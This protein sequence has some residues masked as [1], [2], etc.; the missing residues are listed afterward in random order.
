MAVEHAEAPG[1]HREQA[2]AGEQDA[3]DPDRESALLAVKPWRDQR[4]EERRRDD[5]DEHE[6]RDDERQQRRDGARD[7][8]GLAAIAAREQ[9]GIDRNERR[10]ERALAEEILQDIG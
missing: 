4:D 2:G 6:Q 8:I 3:D 7:T 5:A 10:R 1:G 9:R